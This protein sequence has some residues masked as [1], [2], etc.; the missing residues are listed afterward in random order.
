M[1][2]VEFLYAPASGYCKSS[3]ELCVGD[4]TLKC[5]RERLLRRCRNKQTVQPVTNQLGNAGHE[6]A[7]ARDFHGHGF[8]QRDGQ[9]LGEARENKNVSLQEFLP[10]CLVIERAFKDHRSAE[11]FPGNEGLYR[12]PLGAIAD[13]P[14]SQL[15][16]A[17]QKVGKGTQKDQV[18]FGRNEPANTDNLNRSP[19]STGAQAQRQVHAET[20]HVKFAPMRWITDFHDLA[21]TII[22]DAEDKFGSFQLASQVGFFHVVKLLRPVNHERIGELPSHGCQHADGGDR[23]AKVNM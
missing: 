20:Y 13:Q 14:Q 23:A 17:M 15:I 12:A 22:A 7:D 3:S 18:S 4:Q 10:R 8:H 16:S 1:K 19:R 5:S 6:S 21:A 9:S 11:L 2:I